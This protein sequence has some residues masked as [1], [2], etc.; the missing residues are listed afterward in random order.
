M[1]ANPE[2]GFNDLAYSILAAGIGASDTSITL[3]A[4]GAV[5]FLPGWQSGRA[6]YLTLT[7]SSND[8]EIVKVTDINGDTLTVERGQDNTTAQVWSA[9]AIITQRG[10][11]ADFN[12]FLQ[13]GGYRTSSVNPNGVVTVNYP[14]EKLYQNG[15]TECEKRWFI[16]VSGTT[17]NVLAG[18]QICLGAFTHQE[19]ARREADGDD[20]LSSVDVNGSTVI[21]VSK[22]MN[23]I[24][25]TDSGDT[26]EPHNWVDPDSQDVSVAYGNGVWVRGD[27]DRVYYSN[28]DGVTWTETSWGSSFG[29]LVHRIKYL[30]GQFI[31]VGR[32]MEIQTSSDGTTWTRQHGG[33]SA[34]YD[35]TDIVWDGTNYLLSH[36]DWYSHD[37][38]LYRT[39]DLQNLTL[40][41]PPDT[42]PYTQATVAFSGSR[43]VAIAS[44]SGNMSI[45]YSDNLTNWYNAGSPGA[46]NRG[47]SR[48]TWA[49][50]L[51]VAPTT[52]QT[53]YVKTSPDGTTWTD[54]TITMDSSRLHAYFSGYDVVW[55]GSKFIVVGQAFGS[56]YEQ[57][58]PTTVTSSDGVT[59][60]E[61]TNEITA[62]Y[63]ETFKTVR[64]SAAGFFIT[65]GA[66]P[67]NFGGGYRT[68]LVRGPSPSELY[69]YVLRSG[70]PIMDGW[71]SI[72]TGHKYGVSVGRG[73]EDMVSDFYV[74]DDGVNWTATGY[75]VGTIQGMAY[76]PDNDIVLGVGGW[77]DLW[78][79]D[80]AFSTAGTMYSAF[81]GNDI[82]YGN[83]VWVGSGTA[84]GRIYYSTDTLNWTEV[85][86]PNGYSG[87]FQSI[88]YGNG[89]FVIVGE[90]GAIFTSPDGINWTQRTPD[91]GFTGDFYGVSYGNGFFIAVGSSGEI[92]FSQNGTSWFHVDA[93]ESFSRIF[94]S[95]AF[96]YPWFLVVGERGE[97]QASLLG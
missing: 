44:G 65:G 51:F 45:I 35:F 22:Y 47:V 75:D 26:Y 95:I 88:V 93:D 10:V 96:I 61:N 33:Q 25:S 58:G 57:A 63:I 41:T 15:P 30:N 13:G 21:A 9:G 84:T 6:L 79:T 36:I 90:T 89:M 67:G 3:P 40:I 1:A 85:Y 56:S 74:S 2:H 12:G 87:H 17:W 83:G 29:N 64:P 4:G 66:A 97:I 52:G 7:N 48:M 24:R 5:A 54:R 68:Y 53:N 8:I 20:H 70:D 86:H 31:M 77:N 23:W 27:N 11:A 69:T 42:N 28:D 46:L 19:Y 37:F 38:F 62:R 71:A 94:Y 34:H 14:G 39:T 59:W 72:D 78:K 43:Y 16:G 91:A 18:D 80:G 76:D 55:T 32:G 60:A 49:N 81:E 73:G 82:A 92:Q 50:S